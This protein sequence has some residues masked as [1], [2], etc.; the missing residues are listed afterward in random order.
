VPLGRRPLLVLVLAPVIALIAGLLTL[1][2][3]AEA[4]RSLASVASGGACRQHALRYTVT[5]DRA[6]LQR[7]MAFEATSAAITEPG[8]YPTA[9]PATA[10]LHAAAHSSVVVY[11]RAGLAAAQLAPLRALSARAH[12]TKV[13]LIVAPR[14]QRAAV[15]ALAL[16]RQLACSA[17][18]AAQTARVRAFAEAAYPPLR[19]NRSS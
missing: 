14:A 17:A 15:V 7:Q 10:T 2:A 11:Y 1:G 6:E 16:G 3:H 5:D 8:F 18:D 19:T 4:P 13:P 9:P 12:A